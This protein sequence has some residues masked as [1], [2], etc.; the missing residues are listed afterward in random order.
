MDINQTDNRN[1]TPLYQAAGKGNLEVLQFL[2]EHVAQESISIRWL[3]KY[4]PLFNAATT[5][6]L[7][8]V[9]L[10][11]Q[12]GADLSVTYDGLTLF[13]YMKKQL[14]NGELLSDSYVTDQEK[15]KIAE[16][17]LFMNFFS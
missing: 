14:D 10:L 8:N 4:S 3:N 9:K 6:N 11:I 15:I 16:K 5:G 12:A 7:E 2:L 17:K 13:E 1:L